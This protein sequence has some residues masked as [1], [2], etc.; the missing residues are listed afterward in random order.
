MNIITQPSNRSSFKRRLLKWI[1]LIVVLPI[2]LFI[3]WYIA[4]WGNLDFGKQELISKH[5][6]GSSGYQLLEY[7]SSKGN[8]HLD[9]V[10]KNGKVHGSLK[11]YEASYIGPPRWD[12]DC[13]GVL[14]GGPNGMEELKISP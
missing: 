11:L 4:Y 13:K 10:D 6:C 2:L 14:I 7:R 9:F 8:G 12:E 5:A 3:G 1:L